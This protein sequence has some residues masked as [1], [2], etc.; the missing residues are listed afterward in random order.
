MSILSLITF[1]CVLV[2]VIHGQASSAVIRV[3][4]EHLLTPKKKKNK[5]SKVPRKQTIKKSHLK[6]FVCHYIYSYSY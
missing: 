1:A 6:A 3:F 5:S 2:E 4:L